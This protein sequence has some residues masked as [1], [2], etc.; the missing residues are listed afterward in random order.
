MGQVPKHL[1]IE[2]EQHGDTAVIRLAGELDVAV[3]RHLDETIE[4]LAAQTKTL[5]LDLGDLT[6]IDSSGLR[7]LLRVW[8]ASQNGGPALA[9]VPGAGQV[10]STM[11][12]AGLHEVLPLADEQPLQVARTA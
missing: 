2:P 10:R 11:E 1:T 4:G 8:H 12:L 7:A 5:V 6:F 9:I 3:E